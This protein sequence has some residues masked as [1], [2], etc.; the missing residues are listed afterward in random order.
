MWTSYMYQKHHFKKVLSEWLTMTSET[1]PAFQMF[2]FT[3]V[4][5]MT[6]A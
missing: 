1:L 3:N 6:E 2:V 4:T 5:Y